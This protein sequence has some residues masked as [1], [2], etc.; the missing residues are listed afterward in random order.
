MS[1]ELSALLIDVERLSA[2]MRSISPECAAMLFAL[3]EEYAG[4]EEEE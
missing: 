4:E 2:R 3:W 1:A